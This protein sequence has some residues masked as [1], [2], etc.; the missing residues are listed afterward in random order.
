MSRFKEL[1]GQIDQIQQL[2]SLIGQRVGQ[3]T[4]E[5]QSQVSEGVQQEIAELAQQVQ[6]SLGQQRKAAEKLYAELNP[7]AKFPSVLLK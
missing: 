1:L 5:L 4:A 2:N 7:P 3:M 6:A